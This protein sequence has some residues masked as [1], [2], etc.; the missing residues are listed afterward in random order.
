MK[1]SLN[2]Q[3]E[4]ELVEGAAYYAREANA[5]IANAFVSEFERSATC[6]R[7]FQSSV[8]KPASSRSLKSDLVRVDAHRIKKGEYEGRPNSPRKCLPGPRSTRD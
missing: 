6:L 5:D 2:V 8:K 4:L 1:I 3:A 7:T